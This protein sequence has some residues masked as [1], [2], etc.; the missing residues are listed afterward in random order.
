[1]ANV[2]IES[3][4]THPINSVGA[5]TLGMGNMTVTAANVAI[6]V[7]FTKFN[8]TG[9]GTVQFNGV[10]AVAPGGSYAV[11][12]SGGNIYVSTYVVGAP[13]GTAA[14][15]T[16]TGQWSIVN[17]VAG[18]GLQA[19]MAN[20]LNVHASTPFLGWTAPGNVQSTAV[21]TGSIV[22]SSGNTNGLFL[23]FT[24]ATAAGAATMSSPNGTLVLTGTDSGN[25]IYGGMQSAAGAANF[26]F[27]GTMTSPTSP[28]NTN[29]FGV[30]VNAAL[31]SGVLPGLF[32]PQRR[33]IFR[34][35]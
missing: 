22:N 34:R 33:F 23:G 2:S 15:P 16:G 7:V 1:M 14:L 32:V 3:S 20:L 24:G 17:T 35:S 19:L 11:P 27:T 13:V 10:N 6:M 8:P 26:T 29:S 21:N 30:Y 25:Q 5:A 9:F 31:A 18:T 12:A 4:L 28:A